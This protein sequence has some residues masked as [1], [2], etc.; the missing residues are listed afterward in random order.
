MAY[1]GAWR[2]TQRFT[3]PP[4]D[5]PNLGGGIDAG[6]HLTPGEWVNPFDEPTPTLPEAPTYL[7]VVDDFMLP[8]LPVSDPVIAEPLGHDYGTVQEGQQ[9]EAEARIEAYHAHM[10]DYGAA[11]V[12]H[13]DSPIMRADRDTYATQRIEQEF[14]STGSRLAL[15]RGRN[16]WPENNPD[17]PP[18][19]GTMTMRWIDRQFTRRG[20]TP[21]MQP[22]RPYRAAAARAVPAP[23][24]ANASQ[25]TSPFANLS[26]ARLLKLTPPQQRRVPRPPDEAAMVD[27]TEDPQYAEPAYWD[28]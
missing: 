13:H 9:S 23:G 12:H 27:G 3:P 8:S 22:L 17:G 15:V 19:Q 25:Y 7:Y 18:A 11:A 26:I 14:P 24:A 4:G 6:A 1:T 28:W 2:R 10:D 20:I 5:N 21:D 16:A